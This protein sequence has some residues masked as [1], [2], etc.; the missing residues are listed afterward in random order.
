MKD[1]KS[2]EVLILNIVYVDTTVAWFEA[3]ENYP[4][5][6]IVTGDIP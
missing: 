5:T 1:K 6:F 3:H 2:F 4:R